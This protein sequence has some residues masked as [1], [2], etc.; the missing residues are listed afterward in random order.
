MVICDSSSRDGHGGNPPLWFRGTDA[1]EAAMAEDTNDAV[2][3]KIR[4]AGKLWAVEAISVHG[5][6]R[7]VMERVNRKVA[8]PPLALLDRMTVVQAVYGVERA[9]EDLQNVLPL[10]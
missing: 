10:R 3:I 2:T 7:V 8:A 1:R 4:R 9:L 5:H 6:S